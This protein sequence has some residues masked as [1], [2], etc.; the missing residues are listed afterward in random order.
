MTVSASPEFMGLCRAQL[1]LLAQGF[2]STFGAVYLAEGWTEGRATRWLPLV[3]YPDLGD[4]DRALEPSPISPPPQ[5]SSADWSQGRRDLDN[6]DDRLP[7]Q[8]G[9]DGLELDGLELDGLELDGLDVARLDS[10]IQRAIDDLQP[11]GIPHA[12]PAPDRARRDRPNQRPNQRPSPPRFDETTADGHQIVLPL[13]QDGQVLG[14]L[15][16]RRDRPWTSLDYAQLE[17]IAQSLSMGCLLDRRLN[18]VQDRYQRQELLQE[19]R[20]DILDNWIHQ[21][22]NP[23]M[24]LRTFGKL[25]LRRLQPEDPNRS[26]V[27]SL[28][29]EGDRIESLLAQMSQTIDGWMDV[30]P[31][32]LRTE[33]PIS[34]TQPQTPLLES[35]NPLLLPPA[36]PLGD[37]LILAPCSVAT[38][39]RPLVESLT[40]LAEDNHQSLTLTISDGIRDGIRDGISN[41][42][43][44]N[45]ALAEASALQ[46]VLGNL[47]E[48]A[49]KYSGAGRQVWVQVTIEGD[50]QLIR[51]IDN[52]PGIPSSDL[53]RIFDRHYRGV[54]AQGSKPGS[55]LGL[56]IARD[57]VEQMGGALRVISPVDWLQVNCPSDNSGPGTC[58]EVS[59]GL[60]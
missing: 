39:L 46:E 10:D 60:A 17:Q 2:G 35:R 16:S 20:Q 48:N 12:S 29:R 36:S 25:I 9:Q 50:R 37:R 22:R 43:S 28:I 38:L 1:V 54:Q 41:G 53:G 14:V 30:L 52:G 33:P 4:R 49:L 5:R 44:E 26:T 11:P 8:D 56:A 15:I 51:V 27:E 31:D 19:Q 21:L 45:L 23:L 3:V 34:V 59:L 32:E 13:Q 47:I 55:G 58:F 18:W 7:G 24:A 42:I 57:F 40:I 6:G